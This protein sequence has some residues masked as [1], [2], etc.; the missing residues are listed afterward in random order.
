MRTILVTGSGRG[1]GKHTAAVLAA[2]GHRVILVA[3]TKAAADAT[4]AWIRESHPNA[5]L[6]TRAL[7]LSSLAAVR[8]FGEAL[9]DEGI[10]LD[11]LFHCAGIMQQSAER[12][13]TADGFE[14]TLGVNVLAPFALTAALWP[15]LERSAS[16][17]VV[18][19][20][21]RLHAKTSRGP[22]ADYD[23]SDPFLENGYEPNRA[24][25]N[26]K[27][28]ALWFV[29]E[30]QR[31]ASAAGAQTRAFCVCPGFVPATACEVTSGFQYFLMK[32]VLVWAPF[33]TSIAAAAD[34]LAFMCAD[35]ALDSEEAGGFW[36]AKK[37]FAGSEESR[38]AEK[39]RQFW[40]FAAEKTGR[41]DWL[42][43]K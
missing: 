23:F 10:V 3:R 5:D 42:A 41:T 18:V 16:P 9:S 39:A 36:T 40:E 31:R 32:Y 7:D 6:D 43:S 4:A 11:T 26:S 20:G 28:A 34:S 27:L 1:L 17:R 15:A 12:R 25:K 19:A 22:G 30:L 24:Y 29:S 14:E 35:P 38:D 37:P 13:L 21:S 8:K 33:A 2:A